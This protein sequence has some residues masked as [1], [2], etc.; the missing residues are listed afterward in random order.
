[1]KRKLIR[2]LAGVGLLSWGAGL[3]AEPVQEPAVDPRWN[4]LKD[5]CSEC[6]NATD[7]A[8]GI[9]Y[10]T[11]SPSD[12]PT[13]PKIFEAVVS[14]LR[15]RMMPPPGK[16][17]PDQGTINS[18]VGWMEHGLD[19]AGAAHPDPG[20]VVL[21]RL[22]RT[23]YARAV[24]EMLDL[25]IDPTALL[26]KDTKSDG[27]DNV[28][29]V[30]K[31]SPTFLD[32]YISAARTVSAAALGNATATKS[33]ATYRAGNRDQNDHIEGLPLGTRGGMV[34]EHT[35][36]ADA[37]YE[38]NISAISGAGYING[39]DS[40]NTLVLTIDDQKVFEG[41]L[42]GAKDLKAA[43]QTGTEF[44]SQLKDRFQHVRSKVTA[45]PHTIGLAFIAHSFAESDEMLAPYR[46]G[47]GM[48]RIPRVGGV[49]IVG[50]FNASGVSETP[51]RRRIFVCQPKNAAD[52]EPCAKQIFSTLALHAFRRPVGDADLQAPLRFYRTARQAGSFD[53]GIQSGLVAI[54]ASPKFL[55]R[56]EDVP[57]NLAAGASY[58]INDLDLASRLAFFLWSEGPDDE[59]LSLAA[60][61]KLHEPAVLEAQVNRLLADKR[62]RSLATNFAFQWLQVDSIDKIEPDPTL[63][64]SFDEDLRIAMRREIE[65]FVD[66]VFRQDLNVEQLMTANWT[67]VNE[68]LALHYGIPNV[69]GDVFRRVTLTDSHRFGLLGKSGILMGTSYGNRTAPVLR[70]AWILENI[71]GTPPKAPPANIKALQENVPGAAALTVRQR[72]ELHRNQASCNACHGIMDPLGLSLEN[73]DAIGQ[74]RDRDREAG[75]VIDASG[76]MVTGLKLNGPND[77]RAALMANPE[78]FVQTLTMKLMTF[79]LGRT[80]EYHDMPTIRA[81]VRDSAKSDYRFSSLIM[82]IVKSEPFQKK[83]LATDVPPVLT[84]GVVAT[85][86]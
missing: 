29:N 78:Q 33:V 16:P 26:P 21:H 79:A 35:F 39:L 51:S 43:D 50:P 54:L 77:V 3:M 34:V 11:M 41:T 24:R 75:D 81:I 62:S 10:D 70:G 73:F 45:G 46:V 55:Y 2:V 20:N 7:W 28:A 48:D 56:A 31:V 15:G 80:V 67:F 68:R 52:E 47:G 19:A 76:Q 30:L 82:G 58:R 53:A 44:V 61:H 63:F 72:M 86:H 38:F 65:L 64:P 4:L 6:H 1:M 32:Q 85:P 5:Y 18:F 49:D 23:E 8:G 71:T 25:K 74:W 60:D 12:I 40:A 13:D 27:F 37:E 42:G 83:R 9:A 57:T 66:S 84:T 14:K 22:N 59:L 69:R 36:P 17:Q